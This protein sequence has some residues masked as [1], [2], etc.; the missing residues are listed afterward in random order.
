MH[1]PTYLGNSHAMSFVVVWMLQALLVK[2]ALA[3]T[4]L[5]WVTSREVLVT[6]MIVMVSGGTIAIESG[7]APY[8]SGILTRTPCWL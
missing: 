6:S 5:G 8:S 1:I 4:V 2:R 3:R 7:Y